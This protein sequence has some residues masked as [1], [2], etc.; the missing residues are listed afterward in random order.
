MSAAKLR[1][2]ATP[3][4][5][6]EAEFPDPSSLPS[7]P[8]SSEIRAELRRVLDSAEFDASERNRRFLEYVVE[9]ALAGRAE[10]IKAYSIATLVFGRNASFDPQLD[11]VVRMEAR[12]LRRSLER[13]YLTG[14][15]Q[16]TVRITLPKGAYVP[17][18][19]NALAPAC[20]T[21]A[22]DLHSASSNPSRTGH[23]PVI[24]ITPF[25]SEGDHSINLDYS[26][27][28]IHRLMIGFIR[29]PELCVLGPRE[30][31]PASGCGTSTVAD[32]D[33][34]L[35]GSSAVFAGM[36][37]VNTILMDARTGKVL[38]GQNFARDLQPNGLV[39]ARNEVADCIVQ[40]LAEASA[41]CMAGSEHGRQRQRH[42]T[43]SYTSD[44]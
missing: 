37:D 9:E 22:A 3:S 10:R 41:S 24:Q 13:F 21:S 20:P 43:V 1:L 16:S 17:E 34:I 27:G 4:L 23:A 14:G 35:T 39:S 19:A 40:A 33:F 26:H 29:Y 15:K 36:M 25:A 5:T 2:M 31:T 7:I 18:F 44:S 11:P 28:L 32:A 42:T 30:H 12:R 8:S 6:S 38:W